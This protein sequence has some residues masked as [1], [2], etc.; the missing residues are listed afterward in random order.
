MESEL[1]GHERGAFTGAL[2]PKAGLFEAADGGSILL[3]EIG[4]L[5]LPLQAKLLRVLETQQVLRI[6]ATKSRPID[7]RILA[8]TNCDVA[9]DVARGRFRQDLYYRLNGITLVVPPLRDRPSEIEPLARSFLRQCCDHFRIAIPEL[10]AA[11]L[12]SLRDHSWP[13]NVRELRNVISRAAVLA[14]G[15][16]IQPDDLALTPPAPSRV[17]DSIGAEAE[18]HG[19]SSARVRIER[20]LLANGGNQTRA[21]RSLGVSRRT[22]VR[23][24]ARLNLPRPRTPPG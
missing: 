9:E 6:G 22:L 11:A 5:S 8:A 16:V 18:P 2:T 21:A 19:P 10:S 12:S 3:D 23:Q 4:D 13:G 24:L 7:V 15:N 1:Y 20:A 14:D 17:L